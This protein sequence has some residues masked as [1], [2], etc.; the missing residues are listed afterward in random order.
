MSAVPV[1]QPGGRATLQ[2][3]WERP[4]WP[5]GKRPPEAGGEEGG[6]RH[7]EVQTP[8]QIWGA[9]IRFLR[10]EASLAAWREK[11]AATKTPAMPARVRLLKYS[12]YSEICS[13]FFV[14][15]P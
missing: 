13:E 14:C 12:E 4:V 2:C 3:P 7:Q 6:G 10:S 15:I 9:L 1:L 5:E 11:T 8:N